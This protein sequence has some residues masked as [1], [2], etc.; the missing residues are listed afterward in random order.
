MSH[1]VVIEPHE[2]PSL[3]FSSLAREPLT[4]LSSFSERATELYKIRQYGYHPEYGA[5]LYE[6]IVDWGESFLNPGPARA[7]LGE[8]LEPNELRVALG[9]LMKQYEDVIEGTVTVVRHEGRVTRCIF[10]PKGEY[11]EP[12]LNLDWLDVPPKPRALV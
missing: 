1:L 12:P 10:K 5:T 7:E 11:R 2:T 9:V 6:I 4:C 3:S 8:V